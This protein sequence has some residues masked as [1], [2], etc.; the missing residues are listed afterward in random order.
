MC[1]TGPAWLP[2]RRLFK[3]PSARRP[4][5]TQPLQLRRYPASTNHRKIG[6]FPLELRDPTHPLGPCPTASVRACTGRRG[7][8]VLFVSGHPRGAIGDRAEAPRA[9]Q[10]SE[11]WPPHAARIGLERRAP[12]ASPASVWEETNRPRLA[13]RGLEVS[14]SPSR[15][16][17]QRAGHHRRLPQP[18]RPMS[19][20]LSASRRSR[21]RAACCR[22]R[23]ARSSWWRWC[24]PSTGDPTVSRRCAPGNSLRPS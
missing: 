9:L 6:G 24:D 16:S 21:E 22:I 14:C 2:S 1:R 13:T 8:C 10:R 15:S 11:P 12:E 3:L 7:S 4:Q 19:P 20:T 23:G 5:V 17:L 18:R